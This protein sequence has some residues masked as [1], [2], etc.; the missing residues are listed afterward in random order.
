LQG[1]VQRPVSPAKQAA[2]AFALS[3]H[4]P[5][6]AQILRNQFFANH[7][8]LAHASF[9]GRL[10]QFASRDRHRFLPIIVVG[11]IGP[12]F[13][14][15]AYDDFLNYTFNAYAY[16]TFWPTAYDDVY[17]G[18]TGVYQAGFG[19]GYAPSG[20][21]SAEQ[22][23]AELSSSVCADQTKDVTDWR[24]DQI[25]QVVEP[26]EV[27]RAAFEEFK[28]DMAKA[29]DA[30]KAACPTD[31]PSTPTGRIDAMRVRVSAM[32]EAVRTVRAPVAKFYDL[33]NDEQKA[34]FNA[35]P[36]GQDQ[37]EPERRRN[38]SVLCSARASGISS[39]S[40]RG[41]AAVRSIRTLSRKFPLLN[42]VGRAGN[43]ARPI[44][45]PNSCSASS[46]AAFGPSRSTLPL[47]LL[48]ASV[49]SI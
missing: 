29:A 45:S 43:I 1:V 44:F 49:L 24:I 4:R 5:G 38:L 11:F 35:L 18:I 14:P 37:N 16:D 7:P 9:R 30:L 20:S 22:S 6:S 10:T 28:A 26:D 19:P 47:N 31:L 48:A 21:E 32:L 8:A 3:G 15:Y 13:W 23:G 41:A 33:L 12:L 25:A 42:G 36:S 40:I 34:R 39:V 46:P 27:Q 2:A 17:G